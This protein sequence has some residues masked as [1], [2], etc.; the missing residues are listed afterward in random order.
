MIDGVFPLDVKT[1]QSVLDETL[2]LT[3][4]V[5]T[6]RELEIIE[7]GE[8]SLSVEGVEL[9]ALLKE[10]V[11]LF[12][13]AA[14]A[15]S[16]RLGYVAGAELGAAA[17]G[18]Y[19]RLGQVVYN[20]V[21]NAIKY[22]PAGGAVELRERGG[23][24]GAAGFSVDDSGPG[25]EPGERERIFERFYRTDKSRSSGSGG[26]GLGLSIAAEI[27]KAHGGSIF[28]GQSALGGASFAVTLPRYQGPGAGAAKGGA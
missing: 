21:A 2:R 1:L 28:V 18:D 20:L 22:C 14:A 12:Q 7:S 19:L 6:L 25:I 26:R 15:K 27:V 8:L 10:A 5:D 23:G 3:R 9:S 24:T 17:A 11:S 4:L 13:P 16:I